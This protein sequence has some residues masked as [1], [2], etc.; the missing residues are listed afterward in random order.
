M[1][2]GVMVTFLMAEALDSE[3]TSAQRLGQ[4][5]QR[6]LVIPPVPFTPNILLIV[7]QRSTI[8]ES[9]LLLLRPGA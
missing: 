8:I 6:D 7:A 1:N 3:R 5:E 9:I 2:P 4:S